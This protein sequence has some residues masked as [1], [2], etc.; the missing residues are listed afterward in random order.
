MQLQ[1]H[2]IYS[3]TNISFD[4]CYCI[5]NWC[6][7]VWW[8]SVCQTQRWTWTISA[9]RNATELY[10]TLVTDTPDK[11]WG[12][13]H[14]TMYASTQLALIVL[15]LKI[16]LDYLC[17]AWMAPHHSWQNHVERMIFLKLGLQSIGLMMSEG[18]ETAESALWNCNSLA[19][20]EWVIYLKR[21]LLSQYNPLSPCIL[22]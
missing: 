17:A 2:Q 9:L 11:W 8:T 15:F 6:F 14:C 4:T 22:M 16:N 13:D 3:F 12:P 10:D 21:K 18:S 20:T 5:K 7:L 19:Y 1:F